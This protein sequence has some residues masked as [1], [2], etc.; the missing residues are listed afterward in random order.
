MSDKPF[1]KEPDPCP[2][3]GYV[4]DAHT[5]LTEPDAKP[6]P[7]DVSICAKCAGWNQYN[8]SLKLVKFTDEDKERMERDE[9]DTLNEMIR[10]TQV[11]KNRSTK[12]N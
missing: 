3:C 2:Y 6:K 4:I 7:G 5:S 9:P 1:I 11:I 8:G 12:L 10:I